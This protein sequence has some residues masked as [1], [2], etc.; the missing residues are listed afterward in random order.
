MTKAIG[1]DIIKSLP[2]G[3]TLAKAAK[4]LRYSQSSVRR[5]MEAT[6]YE[7]AK[8]EK[9]LVPKWA[10]DIDWSIPNSDLA[11]NL[12]LSR[13]RIRQVRD[14]LGKPKVENRGRERKP[15]KE[16]AE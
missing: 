7:W 15:Q 12:G 14:L 8:N 2:P 5:W 4:L 10:M 11:R 1:K 13:E 9:S 3:L 6:G 16:R